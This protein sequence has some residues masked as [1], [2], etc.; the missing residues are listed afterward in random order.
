MGGGRIVRPGDDRMQFMSERPYLPPGTLREVLTNVGSPLTPERIR[1]TIKMLDL[2][3]VLA[4]VGGLES[5]RRWDGLLS[6]GEQKSVGFARILL[7]TP[8]VVFLERP[9][10]G[11]DPDQLRRILDLLAANA[12]TIMSI[13]TPDDARGRFYQAALELKNDGGW[14][15]TPLSGS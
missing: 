4:R 14:Q 1:S 7:S 11:I 12:V 8:A 2:E 3:T 6:L 15:Y 9:D 10:T 5:E 13:G